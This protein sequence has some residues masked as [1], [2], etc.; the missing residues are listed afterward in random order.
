MGLGEVEVEV[1]V[2]VGG[3]WLVVVEEE[4][5]EEEEEEEEPTSRVTSNRHSGSMT[6]MA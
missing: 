3:G 1:D 2:V 5:D 6:M 4:E